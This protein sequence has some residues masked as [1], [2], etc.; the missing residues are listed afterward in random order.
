MY[1]IIKDNKNH[2][3][4]VFDCFESFRNYVIY[5]MGG[6]QFLREYYEITDDTLEEAT[7]NLV[8]EFGEKLQHDIEHKNY[9]LYAEEFEYCKFIPFLDGRW[10]SIIAD[11]IAEEYK[12]NFIEWYDYE[13]G[14]QI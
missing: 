12:I 6:I 11:I 2:T 10:Y 7:E 9:D 4:C 3:A 1:Y 13:E 14:R 5:W 8:E